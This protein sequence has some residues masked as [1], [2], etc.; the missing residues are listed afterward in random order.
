MKIKFI[1][2][3]LVLLAMNATAQ[4]SD[5][6]INPFHKRYHDSLK[7]MNYPYNL[8]ILAKKLYKKGFDIPFAWGISPTYFAMRQEILIT[9]T[10]IGLNDGEMVDLSK[11]ITFGNVI[12]EGNFF[13]MRP[14]VWVLPFLNV[15]AIGGVGKANITVPIVEPFVFTTEQVSRSTSAGVGF[16]LA[17]GVKGIILILDNNFVWGWTEKLDKPVPAYNFDGRIAKNFVNPRKADRSVTLW[18][19]GFYQ[20]IKAET[21]G[22]IPVSDV[23]PGQ[24][25]DEKQ[26]ILH[27]LDEWLPTIPAAQHAVASQ[28]VEEIRGY[29]NGTNAGDGVI[30]YQLDKGVAGPWNFI[31]GGQYQHNKNWMIRTEVGTFGKRSQFLLTLNYRFQSFRKKSSQ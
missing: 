16:T 1:L 18:I 11:F 12:A 25:P 30:N 19:G 13:S 14:D 6:E 26:K 31:F 5:K 4:Y 3:F 7:T 17:G 2:L 20:S 15:Y 9:N 10:K 22:K 28:V 29:F 21:Q 27:R 8:P 24:S 23:F